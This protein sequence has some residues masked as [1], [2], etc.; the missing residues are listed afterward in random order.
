MAKTPRRT[1]S[2]PVGQKTREILR[3]AISDPAKYAGTRRPEE[4]FTDWQAKA[5]LCALS[6]NERLIVTSGMLNQKMFKQATRDLKTS[7]EHQSK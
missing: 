3:N 4:A 2:T 5:V 1:I 6:V 7:L